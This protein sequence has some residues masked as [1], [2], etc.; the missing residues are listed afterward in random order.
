ML[1]QQLRRSRRS[2]L[3]YRIGIVSDL[4]TQI[5]FVFLVLALYQLLKDIDKRNAAL[6]VALVLVSVPL[7]FANTLN[8]GAPLILLS[9]ADFLSAFDK[10]QLGALAMGFLRLRTFGINA[11]TAL[12]GLWL[13]PFGLL[14][15]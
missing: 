7:S 14:V 11:V 12:W 13:L 8:L 6:M 15:Y 3:L 2:E 10:H 9:G 1:P 4:L 5:F